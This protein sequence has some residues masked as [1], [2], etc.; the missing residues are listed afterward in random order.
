MLVN[1][2]KKLI[3]KNTMDDMRFYLYYS[4]IFPFTVTISIKS[5]MSRCYHRTV[6]V[7]LVSWCCM[8]SPLSQ[9]LLLPL[10]LLPPPADA[11]AVCFERFRFTLLKLNLI[12]W[13]ELKMFDC[14][15]CCL[16]LC[17][18]FSFYLIP[19]WLEFT[20]FGQSME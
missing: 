8:P 10:L 1:W 19:F 13:G 20:V 3:I 17:R 12:L 7:W 15:F 2:I 18:L 9:S 6:F 16:Y 5:S 11:I 4:L 14:S